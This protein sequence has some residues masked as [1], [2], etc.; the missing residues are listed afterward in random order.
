MTAEI[1]I[2]NKTAIALAADSAVTITGGIQGD[3]KIYNSVNKLFA[4]SKYEPV[5]I[6]IYDGATLMGLPWE[7]I[8]K[9]YRKQLGS[10]NFENL[11]D[12][13]QNFIDFL[14]NFFSEETQ[15]E[16][17]KTLLYG[18]FYSLRNQIDEKVN[19]YIENNGEINE[20]QTISV[21]EDIV[22][23][24]YE[25]WHKQKT[26]QSILNDNQF[27]ENFQNKYQSL[28]YSILDETETL[29]GMRVSETTINKINQI[30]YYIFSKEIL[31]NKTG[32][33]IAGFGDKEIYP[34]LL[35]YEIECVVNNRLKYINI[36]QKSSSID[37]NESAS[38]I[39]FAQDDMISTFVEG[40][41]PDLNS[42][43]NY[44]LKRIIQ[45][46]SGLVLEAVDSLENF[47]HKSEVKSQLE[48]KLNEIN[49]ELVDTYQQDTLKYRKEEHI[50]PILNAVEFLPKD[51][52]AAMAEA[53]INLTSLKRK[54]STVQETVGGPVDVAVIS[55]GDGFIWIKRKH[56]FKPELNH[57]FFRN[58]FE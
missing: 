49:Q 54:V 39:P 45:T 51:E 8:I 6:M 56:Y 12:Y 10:H 53:L 11:E 2:L 25:K 19:S 22:G 58:Y 15:T 36:T 27:F 38:I 28:I 18:Y 16:Y 17:V 34:S 26:I 32:L 31:I 24:E 48:T 21:V 42:F 41:D 33:I 14:Q 43:Y 4:L 47:P 29:K 57:Q 7:T 52:L 44:Y 46:Y 23:K 1:A 3:S 30:S 5:G 55:K 40:V 20:A 9:V 13:A 50:N 35:C 37:S